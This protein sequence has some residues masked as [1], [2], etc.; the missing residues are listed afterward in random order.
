[1]HCQNV[2]DY[3]SGDCRWLEVTFRKASVSHIH[4]LFWIVERFTNLCGILSIYSSDQFLHLRCLC[5]KE[6]W[7][8][9]FRFL[10]LLTET[11]HILCGFTYQARQLFSCL[12]PYME[13][14]DL[15]LDL[16]AVEHSSDIKDYEELCEGEME[17]VVQFVLYQ[18]HRILTSMW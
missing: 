15:K 9:H 17:D 8:N 6:G 7:E 3:I 2:Q 13:S 14:M 4:I 18:C 1:M 16:A 12:R 5:L 11:P 10:D